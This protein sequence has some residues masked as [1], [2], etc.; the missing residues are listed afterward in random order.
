MFGNEKGC[1]YL[2]ILLYIRMY[3]EIFKRC[4][5]LKLVFVKI[6]YNK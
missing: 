5:N 4:V 6:V 2:L 3:I 1:I